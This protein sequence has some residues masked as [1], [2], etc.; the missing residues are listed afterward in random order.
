M[1]LFHLLLP[2]SDGH[3][4]ILG[5]KETMDIRLIF[6]HRRSS[7]RCGTGKPYARWLLLH[8]GELGSGLP[9]LAGIKMGLG[10]GNVLGPRLTLS[11]MIATS[12]VCLFKLKFQVSKVENQFLTWTSHISSGQTP[13]RANGFHIRHPGYEIMPIV[14]RFLLIALTRIICY[15]PI[16]QRLAL[17]YV[18][19]VQPNKVF[20]GV[21]LAMV[22]YVETLRWEEVDR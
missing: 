10:A 11:N 5:G 22:P 14:A 15:S 12:Q 21:L 18:A 1:L 13:Q 20:H 2:H 6:F 19:L 4:R 17:E 7:S 16:E 3:V 9:W 8:I